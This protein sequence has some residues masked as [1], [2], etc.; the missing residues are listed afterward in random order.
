MITSGSALE[1]IKGEYSEYGF[2]YLGD[3]SQVP[4]HTVQYCKHCGIPLEEYG[5]YYSE[6]GSVIGFGWHRIPSLVSPQYRL[7]SRC[8]DIKN[9]KDMRYIND[10]D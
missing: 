10:G 9:K 1:F 6:D 3:F 8:Y 5:K 7:C 4:E 2:N